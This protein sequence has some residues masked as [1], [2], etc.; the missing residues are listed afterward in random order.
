MARDAFLGIT[1]STTGARWIETP[2]NLSSG[3]QDSLAAALID[4]FDDLPL[5]LARI[6]AGMG[7]NVDTTPHYIE[8]KI[9]DLMP[10]PSRF[11]DLDKAAKRL[12]DAVIAKTPIGIFGDYDVDGTAGAVILYR[13]LKRIGLKAHYFIPERLKDGYGPV[14]YTH[15]RAHET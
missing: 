9:R 3:D 4:M 13:Y 1:H 6:M 5:P 8:P 12:A 2:T 11:Q 14:S 15:L 10:N 7:L